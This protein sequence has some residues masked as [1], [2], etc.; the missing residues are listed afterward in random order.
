MVATGGAGDSEN[1]RTFQ[2]TLPRIWSDF[3]P[4]WSPFRTWHFFPSLQNQIFALIRNFLFHFS[5]LE[6]FLRSKNSYTTF[7]QRRQFSY[8]KLLIVLFRT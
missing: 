3:F 6:N 1:Y 7:F 5:D 2:N 4:V 8:F